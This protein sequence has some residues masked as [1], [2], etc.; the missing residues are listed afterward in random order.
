MHNKDIIHNLLKEASEKGFERFQKGQRILYEGDEAEVIR[1]DPLLVIKTSN[2]IVCGAIQ[3]QF[4]IR[5]S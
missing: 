5:K 3:H 2:R 1:V 4:A